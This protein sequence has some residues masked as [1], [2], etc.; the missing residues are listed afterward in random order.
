MEN[1]EKETGND[2]KRGTSELGSIKEPARVT[3]VTSTGQCPAVIDNGAKTGEFPD[4]NPSWHFPSCLITVE[5]NR[6]WVIVAVATYD[7]FLRGSYHYYFCLPSS[8]EKATQ[9]GRVTH[10]AP[11]IPYRITGRCKGSHRT[12]WFPLE[13]TAKTQL[14]LR[15]DHYISAA[16]HFRTSF[17]T[18]PSVYG[19][20]ITMPGLPGQCLR[21][22]R[23]GAT[24][25]TVSR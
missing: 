22:L 12:C 25:E 14:D 24:P 3:F 1:D 15:A 6:H 13:T 21:S 23:P 7:N 17:Q 2:V 8:Q 19:R 4:N 16:S 11:W 9:D 20:S 18:L 5:S 10:S